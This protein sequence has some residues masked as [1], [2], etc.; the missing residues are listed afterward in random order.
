MHALFSHAGLC[1]HGMIPMAFHARCPSSFLL[2][3]GMGCVLLPPSLQ[4]QLL[5]TA[6]E[7]AAQI[8]P[9]DAPPIPVSLEATVIYQD[10]TFTAFLQDETG[11][12]FIP[13]SKDNPRVARGE[14]LRVQGRAHNGLI[15]GGV[16]P[17][18]VDRLAQ[19]PPITPIAATPDDLASGRYHYHWVSLT[20]VGRSVRSDDENTATLRLLTAG[21]TIELRFDEAPTDLVSLVDAELR[22]QGLAA[23]DIN[24]RR[25]LV[26]PYLRVGSIADVQVLKPPPADPFATAAVPLADLQKPN[27]DAHRVKV[28]G[29]ALS[30]PVAGGV[31]LREENGTM[32]VQA[33]AP[34]L[35]AGDVVEALG[36][37]EMGIFSSQLSDA[38]CRVVGTQEPPMALPVNPGDLTDG[39]D[40]EL[41]TVEAQVLQRV[42]REAHTEFLAQAGTVALTGLC[43]GMAPTGLQAG[44]QV[45]LTGLCRVTGTKS[46]GYRARPTAY[47]LWLR[48]M[49]DLELLQRAPWWTT[50][51]LALG[52]GGVAT[53][54][55]IAFLW[56][57]QLRRQVARQLA[58]IEAKAQREAITEERQRIARE[59]HDTLEQELAGLSLRLDAATPRV[60][61]EK[62]RA[63]L[64]QQRRLLLRLQTETRDF[65]WD[66]R[67]S[68]RTDAPLDTA[69]QSLLDHLQVNTTIPLHFESTGPVPLL[70]AL[71]Q[72]HLLRITREAVNNAVKYAGA[73]S[74]G[75]QLDHE[76]GLLTLEISDD[77]K[78]FDVTAADA[79][80]GH[81]GIRGIRER[82]KKLGAELRITSTPEEGSTVELMLPVPAQ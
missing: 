71:M 27:T 76:A 3:A 70:P 61:D 44:A 81:F 62:A 60:T 2:L 49:D 78:G 45:R 72:H 11:V 31:F 64:E 75:V 80:D 1:F 39:T 42:D 51:R 79:L 23:G 68:T 20:G 6:R 66:L 73:S 58:V 26:R 28:R 48:T 37:V 56:A 82:A 22:V 52:L 54:A 43:P 14:R 5:T 19:G 67:D 57:A 4:S 24:D 74:I 47:N 18:R 8:V 59:F 29:V 55:L 34:E 15:I 53:L 12:T 69:L 77:G 16:K 35:K 17:S 63:L 7:V 65:V 36:F 10:P 40:A 38:Q 25:Q 41:I 50:Q 30:P 46:G 32:F 13:G 9:K 33:D 21:K